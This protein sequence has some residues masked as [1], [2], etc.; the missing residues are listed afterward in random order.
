MFYQDDEDG[1]AFQQDNDP[2]HTPKYAVSWFQRRWKDLELGKSPD[3]NP[4]EHLWKELKIRIHQQAT[5]YY[6]FQSV[7]FT[8]FHTFVPMSLDFI[9]HNFFMDWNVMIS[10]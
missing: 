9:A 4:V 7:S 1:L 6:Q 5:L 3:L 8:M 2:K 10:L